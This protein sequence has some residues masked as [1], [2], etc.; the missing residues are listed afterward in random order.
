MRISTS[1][2]IISFI[3]RSSPYTM[4]KKNKKKVKGC[5]FFHFTAVLL[6][7]INWC[8]HSKKKNWIKTHWIERMKKI[9]KKTLWISAQ[10]LLTMMRASHRNT[11]VGNLNGKHL[12]ISLFGDYIHFHS[13][14]N[15]YTSPAY[16][17]K[18]ISFSLINLL[19]S[20]LFFLSPFFWIFFLIFSFFLRFTPLRMEELWIIWMCK[21]KK[22]KELKK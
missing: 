19:V 17:Y 18:E 2:S 10:I 7:I 16:V 14:R 6:L 8:K 22:E 3:F 20:F 12:H 15:V 9:G 11:I 4:R 5:S 21:R 1:F 13:N